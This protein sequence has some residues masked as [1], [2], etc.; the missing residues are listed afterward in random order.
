[1]SGEVNSVYREASKAN[2]MKVLLPCNVVATAV[3]TLFRSDTHHR[4]CS[5]VAGFWS[6]CPVLL[7]C[8]SLPEGVAPGYI[9][10]ELTRLPEPV[11]LHI[12]IGCQHI[13]DSK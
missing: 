3:F 5:S 13:M 1:M 4:P 7:W 11:L 12:G 6:A 9:A 2:A 8:S 10:L